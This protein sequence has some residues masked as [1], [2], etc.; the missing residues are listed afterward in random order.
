MKKKNGFTLI[1][2]LA[3][4][5]II[6]LLI[7]L[8]IP[9][10]MLIS[11]KIKKRLYESKINNIEVAVE[12]YLE[13]HKD[14]CNP[15]FQD[16]LG[17]DLTIKKLVDSNYLKADSN[18]EVK[19]PVN[20]ENWYYNEKK[21]ETKVKDLIKDANNLDKTNAEKAINLEDKCLAINDNIEGEKNQIPGES[22]NESTATY[23]LL[24]NRILID[25]DVINK[26]GS[27]LPSLRKAVPSDMFVSKEKEYENSGLYGAYDWNHKPTFY[28]RGN[29]DNNYVMFDKNDKYEKSSVQYKIKSEKKESEFMT[30]KTAVGYCG[31]RSSYVSYGFS[32]QQSC[33][34]SI[35]AY[36]KVISNPKMLWK[37]VRINEDGTIRMVLDGSIGIYPFDLNNN[38]GFTHNE[39]LHSP[40]NPVYISYNHEEKKFENGH[41]INSNVKTV[42][43]Q[44]YI[45]NLDKYDN[46]L[47]YGLFISDIDSTKINKKYE[48]TK[49]T[50]ILE[51]LYKTY[52]QRREYFGTSPNEGGMYKLKIGLLTIEEILMAGVGKSEYNNIKY[53]YN[54]LVNSINSGEKKLVYNYL[55]NSYGMTMSPHNENS[56]FIFS[57]AEVKED[58]KA[59]YNEDGDPCECDSGEEE[60]CGIVG[61]EDSDVP[62]SEIPYSLD[63]FRG[64]DAWHE[65]Y[66]DI[67]H[68]D[69]AN[70][71]EELN[72]SPVINLKADI[73]VKDGTGTKND[74]Y[75]ISLD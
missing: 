4:I 12:H 61:E 44:W 32:D 5:A 74:P 26:N 31:Q 43:E 14:N 67:T 8:A 57:P 21:G 64:K 51:K 48:L 29:V 2:L 9:S 7:G 56:I 63:M 71:N 33:M 18:K 52:I 36:K 54:N 19:N 38:A 27:N 73:N 37:I 25:N 70:A 53:S 23:H 28:F 34:A 1:E 24:Y 55:S 75:I 69:S 20:N 65:W 13:D 46:Y 15:D 3:V 22:T 11:N 49:Y 6:G 60:F 40:T 30:Y 39:I 42:L 68:Y 16:K 10:T 62:E 45:N 66:I 17:E 35:V 72:V 41:A 50:S 59:C 47:D 58:F